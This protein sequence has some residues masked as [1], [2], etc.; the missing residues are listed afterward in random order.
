[1]YVCMYVCMF[2]RERGR[3]FVFE[4]VCSW[5]KEIWVQR[6]KYTQGEE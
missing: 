6:R 2:V 4:G 3:V 5:E 1:M